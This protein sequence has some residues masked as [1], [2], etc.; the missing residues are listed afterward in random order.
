MQ[1]N[2]NLVVD[3]LPYL[4]DIKIVSTFEYLSCLFQYIIYSNTDIFFDV[5]YKLIS[6]FVLA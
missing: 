5:I 6:L 4:K 3:L 2:Y 1:L